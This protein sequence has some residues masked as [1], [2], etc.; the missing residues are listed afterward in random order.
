MRAQDIS[1]HTQLQWG[2]GLIITWESYRDRK[3]YTEKDIAYK[4]AVP[5]VWCLCGKG[6]LG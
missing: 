6:V 1:L 4:V 5:P 2:C 3:V